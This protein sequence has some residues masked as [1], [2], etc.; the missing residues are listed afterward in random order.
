MVTEAV[1]RF[2][3]ATYQVVAVWARRTRRP[4]AARPLR[5][6]ESRVLCPGEVKQRPRQA[7]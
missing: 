2:L 7:K 3:I 5:P 4:V 6:L 1:R